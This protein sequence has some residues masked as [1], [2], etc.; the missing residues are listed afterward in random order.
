MSGSND[1]FKHE[2]LQDCESIVK[3][4]QAISEGLQNGHLV[5]ANGES[6]IELRPHGLLKLDLKARRKD[7][8][9]KLSFKISW[10]EHELPKEGEATP[11]IINSKN[12]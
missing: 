11:L 2:S 12:E 7:G 9:M 10:K 8:R 5:L 3:Y 1:D 6:P 4:L